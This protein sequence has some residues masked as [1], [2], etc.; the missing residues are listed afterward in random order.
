MKYPLRIALGC[1]WDITD[2]DLFGAG[3]TWLNW[4]RYRMIVDYKNEIPGIFDD[5]NSNPSNW[6]NTFRLHVGYE[7]VLNDRWDLRYGLTYD[8]A[9]EPEAY[10]TLTGG[11]V[12]DAWLLTVGGGV[13]LGDLSIDFGYIYT[14]GPSVEGYIPD[15]KYSMILHEFFVGMVKKF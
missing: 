15:A 14:Y 1:A 13:D 9:P 11:Q 4:N 6:R 5:Y 10:R 2:R 8:Q 3:L 12:I 7:R